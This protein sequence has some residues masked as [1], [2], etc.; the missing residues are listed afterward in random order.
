MALHTK[1]D[2][3][4]LDGRYLSVS[5]LLDGKADRTKAPAAGRADVARDGLRDHPRRAH[6]RRQRPSEP[7]DV[8]DDVDGAAGREAD[9]REP[10]TRT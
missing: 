5:P 2:G 10:S 3:E 6:A 8:R 9:G 1:V 4:G 7:G